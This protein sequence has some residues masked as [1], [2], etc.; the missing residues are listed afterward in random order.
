MGIWQ[1]LGYICLVLL[2]EKENCDTILLANCFK[3]DFAYFCGVL[4]Q[5][6][7]SELLLN[8]K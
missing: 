4:Y 5:M 8:K 1:R 7:A 3:V 2:A 6:E